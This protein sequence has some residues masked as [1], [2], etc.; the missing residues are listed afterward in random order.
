MTLSIINSNYKAPILPSFKVGDLVIGTSLAYKGMVV[1]V[2]VKSG[3]G[4]YFAGTILHEGSEATHRRK[5]GENKN[6]LTEGFELFKGDVRL[7]TIEK[8]G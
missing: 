4:N 2:S 6:F 1:I 3:D 8:N 5:I 7:S